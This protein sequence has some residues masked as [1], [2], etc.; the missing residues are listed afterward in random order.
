MDYRSQAEKYPF[1]VSPVPPEEGK[2]YYVSSSYFPGIL[3]DEE[4]IDAAVQEFQ[5][6]LADVICDAVENERPLPAVPKDDYSGKLSL[7]L[8]TSLHRQLAERAREEGVSINALIIQ[9]IAQGLGG[10]QVVYLPAKERFTSSVNPNFS[11]AAS[12]SSR[13][14]NFTVYSSNNASPS[15]ALHDELLEM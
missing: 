7:R 10:P 3:V 1:T 14:S 12:H 5:T 15:T 13:R 11:S 2:G 6:V 9:Y 8:S 4:T